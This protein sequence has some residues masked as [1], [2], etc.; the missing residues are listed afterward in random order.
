[1][2]KYRKALKKAKIPKQY[3]KLF[4]E[5]VYNSEKRLHDTIKNMEKLK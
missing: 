1:M 3:I 2:R 4:L 5:N